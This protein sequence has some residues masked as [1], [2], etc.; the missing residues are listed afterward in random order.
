M[1]TPTL[2]P[3]TY[4]GWLYRNPCYPRGSNVSHPRLA[5]P[6]MLYVRDPFRSRRGTP[7]NLQSDIQALN[8][9]TRPI[10]IGAGECPYYSPRGRTHPRILWAK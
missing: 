2:T 4:W 9:C 5:T 3:S 7:P 6:L 8:E 1:R 10:S